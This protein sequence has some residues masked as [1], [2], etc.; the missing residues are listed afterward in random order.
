[1]LEVIRYDDSPCGAYREV[2]LDMPLGDGLKPAI[3][4][5]GRIKIH[6]YKL[7][8]CSLV[9]QGEVTPPTS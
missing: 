7:F 1:M 6:D 4:D 3:P 8:C 5:F 2:A 9:C